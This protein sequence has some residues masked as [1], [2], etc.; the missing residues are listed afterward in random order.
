MRLAGGVDQLG[1]PFGKDSRHD[2]VLGAH[3]ACLVEEDPLATQAVGA[4]L[5]SAVD[6]D[7]RPELLERVDVRVEGAPADEVASWR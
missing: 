5:E 4:Q 2:G 3:H 6:R 1:L 7:L